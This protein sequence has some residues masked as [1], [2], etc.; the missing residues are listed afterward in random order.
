[1]N[2]LRMCDTCNNNFEES[3]FYWNGYKYN[4]TC[5]SC[6][7]KKNDIYRKERDLKFKKR[8]QECDKRHDAYIKMTREEQLRYKVEQSIKA[9]KWREAL[10]FE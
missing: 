9:A 6:Q 7:E 3:N 1:M 4:T 8:R 5:L 10:G 2:N